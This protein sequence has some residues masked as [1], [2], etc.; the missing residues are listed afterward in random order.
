MSDKRKGKFVILVVFLSALLW[1]VIWLVISSL[2]GC[3]SAPPSTDTV[4]FR[5]VR[6]SEIDTNGP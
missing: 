2:F 4:N 3:S 1:V 6:Y 5:E